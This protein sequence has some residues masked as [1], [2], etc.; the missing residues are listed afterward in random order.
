MAY[1]S[2]PSTVTG[3]SRAK[4]LFGCEMNTRMDCLKPKLSI[5]CMQEP[6]LSRCV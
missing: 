1:R 5:S 6:N 3:M 4:L 2:T